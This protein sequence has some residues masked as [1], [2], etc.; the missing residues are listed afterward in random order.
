MS[1]QDSLVYCF[2]SDTTREFS[3]HSESFF[4]QFKAYHLISHCHFLNKIR[5]SFLFTTPVQKEIRLHD[6]FLDKPTLTVILLLFPNVSKQLNCLI[7]AGAENI[8]KLVCNSHVP[9]FSLLLYEDRFA[10]FQFSGILLSFSCLLKGNHR[11]LRSFQST[12]KIF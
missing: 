8:D 7:F 1:S 2:M 3:Y 11:Y 4:L 6:F 10:L 5:L 9:L 12:F